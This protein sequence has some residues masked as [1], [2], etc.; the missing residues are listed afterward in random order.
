MLLHGDLQS[1][2]W[3]TDWRIQADE[4][5]NIE[6]QIGF[7]E[8]PQSDEFATLGGRIFRKLTFRPKRSYGMGLSVWMDG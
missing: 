5:K 4:L 3:R 7:F 1:V 6:W 2:G 8:A